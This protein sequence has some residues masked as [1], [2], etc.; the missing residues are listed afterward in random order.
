MQFL[1]FLESIRNPILD[2]IMSAITTL[3]D[4]M[5][6][7]AIAFTL[8]WC[9]DKNFGYYIVSVGLV[10]TVATQFLKLLCRVPRPWVLDPKLTTVGNSI[11]GAGGFSFPSGHTQNITT[12][13]GG[14]AL[15]V[16]RKW[17]TVVCAAI[18]FLVAFSRMYLGVHTP[19]DVAAGFLIA[20]VFA[21]VQYA[22]MKKAT[23]KPAYMYILL[24]VIAFIAVLY[25]IYTE[26]LPADYASEIEGAAH[27]LASGKKNAYKL[28]AAILAIIVC[29][30]LDTKYINFETK[31][32]LPAQV[33]KVAVG[34]LLVLGTKELTKIV[35]VTIAGADNY[36]IVFAR[37]FLTVI[38]G[39]AIYPLTF[40]L[41][42]KIGKKKA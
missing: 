12:T 2:A 9:I 3:G 40:P 1:F 20:I 32:S 7:L 25:L 14:I 42:A 36:F 24:G 4:E 37:Y 34:L 29:Y 13:F 31:A 15:Y 8:F 23:K 28:L 10:S 33:L 41:F 26:C 18:I 30:F 38:V 35:L 27:N 39:C 16:R 19:Y 22:V 11:E 21:L 17:L 5:V 6:F